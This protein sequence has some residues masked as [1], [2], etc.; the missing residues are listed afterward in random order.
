MIIETYCRWS[1][2]QYLIRR[3][4]QAVSNES[5]VQQ[6]FN[7]CSWEPHFNQ[8]LTSVFE[9]LLLQ[10][11]IG[12]DVWLT[13]WPPL[14][15]VYKPSLQWSLRSDRGSCNI[16]QVVCTVNLTCK[17]M[18]LTS[19]CATYVVQALL[20]CTARFSEHIICVIFITTSVSQVIHW[21]EQAFN[22][23]QFTSLWTTVGSSVCLIYQIQPCTSF[24]S[25]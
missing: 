14:C 13:R 5:E 22:F 25:K 9:S 12:A 1:E 17:L 19:Q 10:Y 7:I 18:V 20:H 8:V 2:A 4:W 21:G 6:T 24:V 11:L 15:V 3:D 23:H 16:P